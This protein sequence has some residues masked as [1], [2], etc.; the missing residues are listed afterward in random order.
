MTSTTEKPR[1]NRMK[2]REVLLNSIA[3]LV[4]CTAVIV[5]VAV[6]FYV[7]IIRLESSPKVDPSY[8][9][10]AESWGNNTWTGTP[11]RTVD[12]RLGLARPANTAAEKPDSPPVPKVSP[13]PKIPP[14]PAAPPP[15]VA[16]PAS[17]VQTLPGPQASLPG[18]M[19]GI[20]EK[21]PLIEDIVRRF[22]TATQVEEKLACS[23][24][25]ERV[26]P[27]MEAFYKRRP[28]VAPVWKSLGW[29]L[30]VEEPGQRL[31]YAQAIL[32]DADPVSLIIEEAHD[33]TIRVDWES[34]VRYSEIEWKDF[35]AQ[36]PGEPT[37]FRVIASR[38]AST[39]TATSGQE[40]I[41]LKHP[42]EQG[43]VLGYFDKDDPNFRPLMEQLQIG[44]WKNVPLT[45]RICYPGPSTNSKAVRIAT[46]EG[47]GWLILQT[48]RS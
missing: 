11:K 18:G 37:L 26:R 10:A 30:P 3:K 8:I 25:P 33:G 41:E 6:V 47:K 4:G 5:T 48:T 28:L 16:A 13:A 31:A 40:V 15:P 43:T 24:D 45:L 46:V 38:P 35:L 14:A 9:A 29:V 1:L 42:A 22:L 34:S 21:T 32:A 44:N 27:L 19:S 2:R 20:K 23:R 39:D 17:V 7:V 12:S 36:R